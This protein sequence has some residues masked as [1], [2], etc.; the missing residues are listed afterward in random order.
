MNDL[1]PNTAA[2]ALVIIVAVARNGVIGAN[3][4]IPWHLPEDLQHFKA[5]TIGHAVIMGRKTFDSIG[6]PLPG[7]RI[8]VVTRNVNW[9]HTGCETASSLEAAIVLC[10]TDHP[11]MHQTNEIFVAGGAQLY[12]AALPL[13]S[14]MLI[15]RI[16]LVVEGDTTFPSP[17]PMLWSQSSSDRRQSKNGVEYEI[18]NWR[19][20]NGA[21]TI[22]NHNSNGSAQ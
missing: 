14:R 7:R 16:D 20:S 15:T 19:R 13:A 12:C 2:P 21:T 10:Q 3:N 1:H 11:L 6:R 18:Q 9:R 17:D 4:A 8:I 22:T 5:A